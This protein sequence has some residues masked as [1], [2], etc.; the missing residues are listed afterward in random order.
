MKTIFDYNPTDNELVEL[1]GFDKKSDSMAYGFSVFLLPVADYLN[2]NSAEG[3]LLDVAKLLDLRGLTQE[4]LE[5][6]KQIPD[7]ARQY[8]CGFDFIIKASDER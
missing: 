8:K 6:W 2:E 1:F 4:A 3:K 5:I 7:I